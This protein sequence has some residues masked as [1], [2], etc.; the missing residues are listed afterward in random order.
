MLSCGQW[1]NIRILKIAFFNLFGN[2][3]SS[4][5]FEMV[6]LLRSEMF[7]ILTSRKGLS[8]FHDH[9][10]SLDCISLK[11]VKGDGVDRLY[12]MFRGTTCIP[13]Q[14]KIYLEI[15]FIKSYNLFF[16]IQTHVHFHALLDFNNFSVTRSGEQ[17]LSKENR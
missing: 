12:V 16:S 6:G 1:F 3:G 4:D 13:F 11:E 8:T 10:R 15:H 14:V 7:L 5:A 17:Y 9:S 2:R